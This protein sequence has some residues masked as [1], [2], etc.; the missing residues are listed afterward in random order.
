M[1]HVPWRINAKQNKHS[2]P[3]KSGI[4]TI[5][6][7]VLNSFR[8]AKKQQALLP[9]QFFLTMLSFISITPSL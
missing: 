7:Q 2:T 6:K 9:F 5:K 4:M 3:K 1:V 8:C